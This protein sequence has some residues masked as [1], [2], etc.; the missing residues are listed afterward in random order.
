[1]VR[2]FKLLHLHRTT[3][4]LLNS[5][6][7]QNKLI[8]PEF[9]IHSPTPPYNKTMWGTDSPLLRAHLFNNFSP[10]LPSPGYR[11]LLHWPKTQI[12]W[13]KVEWLMSASSRVVAVVARCYCWAWAHNQQFIWWELYGEYLNWKWCDLD[14]LIYAANANEMREC[15]KH[16]RRKVNA[17]HRVDFV[18]WTRKWGR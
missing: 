10:T 8:S 18:K 7:K 4:I 1:M 11:L 3:N 12:E 16:P 6:N 14:A 17:P 15:R 2:N 9:W 13:W 5:F